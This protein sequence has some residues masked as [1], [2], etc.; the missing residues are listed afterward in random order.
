M[1]VKHWKWALGLVLA[2]GAVAV[3]AAPEVV[4]KGLFANRALLEINGQPRVMKAGEVSPEG[5]R[6][7]SSTSREAQVEINGQQQTL[8]LSQQIG[9][10]FTPAEYAEVRIPRS[11]DSHYWVQ[12]RINGQTVNML[13]DT[14]ATMITLN[15]G[16]A[17]RLGLDYR[18]GTPGMTQTAGGVVN[19]HA[20]TIDR[21]SLGGINLSNVGAVVLEGS[22]PRQILLGNSLLSRLE[23]SESAGSLVLR[24]KY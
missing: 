1:S 9:S 2:V 17:D 8:T 6:L 12:A 10:S 22:F 19:H 15:R 23:M 5:V 13:V 16:E 14:G 3:V 18:Q 4:V 11:P 20:I 24:Q 21:I 7:V